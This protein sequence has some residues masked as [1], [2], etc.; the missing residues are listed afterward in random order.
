[1][2]SDTREGPYLRTGDLG[3]VFNQ[4]KV[5]E[6]SRLFHS[7]DYLIPSLLEKGERK[8]TIWNYPNPEKLNLL[9]RSSSLGDRMGLAFNPRFFSEE[10]AGLFLNNLLH[11]IQSSLD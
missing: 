3:F 2:T 10:E 5:G 9:V 7:A 11:A 1:M 8:V 4:Y 6:D